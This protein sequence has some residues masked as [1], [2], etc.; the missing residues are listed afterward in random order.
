MSVLALLGLSLKSMKERKIRSA[1]TILMVVIGAALI[2]ALHGMG[3]GVSEYITGEL[4]NLSTNVVVVMSTRSSFQLTDTVREK[5]AKIEGVKEAIPSVSQRAIIRVGD[6][7]S[8]ALIMGIDQ[9]KLPLIFPSV[10]IMEGKF[11]NPYDPSASVIGY[12]IAFPPEKDSRQVR[13]GQTV[14]VQFIDPNGD[15]KTRSFRVD[16]ILSK[17]GTTMFI[18]IDSMI[19]ISPHTAR[20]LFGKG[21]VYSEIFVLT[22]DEESALKVA[23]KIRQIYGRNVE[24]ITA[25]FAINIVQNIISTIKLFV[26]NAAFVSLIVAG[27]G[28]FSSLYTSVTER[29]REIGILKSLGFKKSSILLIFLNEAILVGAIGGLLGEIIGIGASYILAAQAAEARRKITESLM[30]HGM[31]T[32]TIGFAPPVFTW[33]FLLLVW[34]FCVVISVIAGF[35]PS[36]K[37]S[38]LDPVKALR[39]E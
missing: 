2:T 13:L 24:P 30:Q 9:T 19:F 17:L 7:E 39:R 15:V 29:V 1:I 31:A 8:E 32:G 20:S 23:E 11:A 6:F 37:A 16:G 3:T 14:T 38:R 35:Y 22:E 36:W 26:M 34:V 18:R 27:V 25:R 4:K 28:I 12:N 33:D 21:G 5:I 10:R